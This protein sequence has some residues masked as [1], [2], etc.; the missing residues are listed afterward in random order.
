MKICKKCNT[1]KEITQFYKDTKYRD[2]C[3]NWCKSCYKIYSATRYQKNKNYIQKRCKQW[4]SQHKLQIAK[5]VRNRI[6][7]DIN[8][9][10]IFNLRSRL[11]Q[12]LKNHWKSGSAIDDLGCSI[13]QLKQ[14]L[15]GQF[16]PGMTWDNWSPS[17]WHVDHINALANFNL[18]DPVEL[19]KACHYTNL[20]PLWASKNC[21]KGKNE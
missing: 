3:S 8:T 16:S 20:Q 11:Y 21:S 6:K 5:R 10:L 9:R 14:H 12:A 7:T 2:N 13:D 1:T 19:K 4:Q 18:S 15:E 17:G